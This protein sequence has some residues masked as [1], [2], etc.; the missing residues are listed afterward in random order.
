MAMVME[1]QAQA[2]D[3]R[4][5]MVVAKALFDGTHGYQWA[6]QLNLEPI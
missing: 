3:L 6:S 5:V 4:M 1:T 2:M